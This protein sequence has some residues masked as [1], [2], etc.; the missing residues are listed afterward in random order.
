MIA[1]EESHPDLAM[2]I[3]EQRLAEDME[4]YADNNMTLKDDLSIPVDFC[5]ACGGQDREYSFKKKVFSYQNCKKCGCLHVERRLNDEGLARLY[6]DDGRSVMQLRELYIPNVSYRMEHIYRPKAENLAERTRG[7]KLL[8]FGCSAGYFMLAAK[9]AGMEVHGIEANDFSV[10]WSRDEL[11]LDTVFHG[12]L[13]DSHFKK[14]YFDF[15]TMWDVL[16]HV[17]NP[18]GLLEN[19]RPYMK[20]E[21]LLI[22]ETSHIDCVEADYL[23]VDNTNVVGDVHLMHFTRKSLDIIANLAGYVVDSYKIFGLDLCHIINFHY[24]MGLAKINIPDD[25]VSVMQKVIDLAGR[26]CYIRVELKKID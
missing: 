14:E 24:R 5:P 11:G 13:N 17:P 10:R 16:E 22:I 15:I 26:G 3:I 8:D 1:G 12:N 6:G 23:G 2:R 25:L 9:E 19:V 20:Q 21:G 4:C 7:N 18:V